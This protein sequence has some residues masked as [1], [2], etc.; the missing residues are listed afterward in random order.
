MT[1]EEQKKL[2]FEIAEL[3]DYEPGFSGEWIESARL[4]RNVFSMWD[5]ECNRIPD[6]VE[7][8]GGTGALAFLLM[9][10]AIKANLKDR[11]YD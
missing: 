10:R 2:N 7:I 9:K 1:H 11:R 4:G 8:L 5:A 3:E 6:Y